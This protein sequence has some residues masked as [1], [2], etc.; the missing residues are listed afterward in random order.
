MSAMTLIRPGATAV[1]CEHF[2][3]PAA[4]AAQ[5]VVPV[6]FAV[7]RD[8]RARILLVRRRDTGD[9][10]LPG[11]RVDPGESAADAVV[12]EV[13]EEA[14]LVVTVGPVLDIDSDPAHVVHHGPGSV[15]CQPFAVCVAAV[16]DGGEPRGDGVE[17]SA[18][19]WW[20]LDDVDGL[21]MQPAVRRRLARALEPRPALYLG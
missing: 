17:T 2:H 4:P 5:Y 8:D 9:W 1:R 7:V 11:G 14:G 6:V 21:A 20:D 10:E 15:V 19:R 3:D 16:A 13:A 12:R 18:A